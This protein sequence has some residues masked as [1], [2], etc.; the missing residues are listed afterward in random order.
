VKYIKEPKTAKGRRTIGIDAALVERLRAYRDAMKNEANGH[1]ADADVDTSL[2]RL[3]AGCLLFPGWPG[4][5][6]DTDYTRLRDGHAISRTFKRHA[7]KVGFVMKFH[8]LRASCLTAWLD[9]GEPVHVVA[10]RAGHDPMTLLS[11]YARWTKKTD[12]KVANVLLA[13]SEA[14]V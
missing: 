8:N 4:P 12:A 3:P 1:L 9:A 14:S 11:S 2:L 10:K 7:A 6:Q 5:G 13:M